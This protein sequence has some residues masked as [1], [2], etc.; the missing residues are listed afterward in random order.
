MLDDL[1][2]IGRNAATGGVDRFAWSGA[3]LA[4]REWFLA[5]A[6]GIGLETETD[7]NGNLWAWWA[8]ALPGTA[9]VIG[10]HLDSV[11]SGGDWDGPLGVVAALD[12]VERLRASGF[13]PS[14]PIAVVAFSDEE[15]ARFG[16][17]CLGSRLLL[18][19]VRAESALG[20]RDVAGTTLAEAM[21]A[22]GHD[23]RRVGADPQRASRIGEF[24][25]LHIEQGHLPIAEGPWR[26]VAGLTATGRTLGVA[27]E[28]W[29][30]GRWRL[31]FEG[32]AN[33]AGTTPLRDRNDPVLA[34]ARGV[35]EVRKAAEELGVLGTVGKLSVVPGAVN[36]IAS[37]ASIWVDAR[38][39][40]AAGVKAM[41]ALVEQRLGAG[42][43]QES[44]TA[45]TAFDRELTAAVSAAVAPVAGIPPVLP[46]GAGHDAGVLALAGIPTAM[47]F[48]RNPTGVSHSPAEAVDESD[49]VL[50]VDALVAVLKDRATGDR[51][52]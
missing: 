22:A 48:V 4:L 8:S 41:I 9:V 15:G 42:A 45:V 50:G 14:R 47:L 1:R 34:L 17:A 11:P 46:S 13:R 31:D 28:I 32:T 37:S 38:G 6:D 44:W 35:I 21:T 3:D 5:R 40:D 24:I 2:D 26:G 30:H 52:L 12:A 33:H 20:L 10:S 18:G 23:P 29:P 16:V 36:A 43:V 39:P 25:E 49:A 19:A 7:G 51:A 27:S